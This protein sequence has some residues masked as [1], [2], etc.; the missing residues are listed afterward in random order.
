MKHWL[1]LLLSI[2]PSGLFSQT[3]NRE[4]WNDVELLCGTLL[5]S[6]ELPVKGE[7]NTFTEKSKPI[8]NTFLRLYP[9]SE[10]RVCC[11]GLQPVAEANS[12]HHGRFAF[13]NITPGSYWVVAKVEGTDY[14]LAITYAPDKKT[15]A[16]C[17]DI[18]YALKENHLVIE[19]L[20]Q[21]D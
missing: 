3:P 10:G 8:K 13:K 2:L 21:V 9:R 1:L 15:E 6:E 18:L 4:K 16:K 5:R 17:S 14:Q 19:R 11:D 7:A 20:I 12:G